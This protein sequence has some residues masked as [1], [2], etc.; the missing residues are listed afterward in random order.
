[1]SFGGDIPI[2]HQGKPP[3]TDSVRS[4]ASVSEGAPPNACNKNDLYRQRR[5]FNRQTSAWAHGPQRWKPPLPR[6][7][8]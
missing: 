8:T 3:G 5:R 4:K 7:D 1:M 2:L 6:F